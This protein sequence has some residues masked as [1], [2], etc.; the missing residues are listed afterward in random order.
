[1]EDRPL[2]TT[3]SGGV[4][5]A[6][7]QGS[8][9]SMTRAADQAMYRAKRLGRNRIERTGNVSASADAPGFVRVA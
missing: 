2:T 5:S 4:A 7:E 9:S 1:V 8:V 3:V 6:A